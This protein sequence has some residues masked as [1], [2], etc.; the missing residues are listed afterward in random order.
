MD[1]DGVVYYS[2]PRLVDSDGDGS[3]DCDDQCPNDADKV[4]PGACGCGEVEVEGCGESACSDQCPNDPGIGNTTQLNL[5]HSL[6][7]CQTS[8]KG[9][10]WY[11]WVWCCRCG[12]R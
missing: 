11:L 3:S 10:S 2:L 8:R 4:A 12:F 1:V 6:C 5:I 9:R 7:P